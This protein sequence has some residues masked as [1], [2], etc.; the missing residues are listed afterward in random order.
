MTASA[1]AED[2]LR[3]GLDNHRLV[4]QCLRDNARRFPDKVHIHAIDQDKAIT[5]SET[6][7]LCNRFAR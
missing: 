6:W 1:S 2:A 4:Q 5:W 7:R 3:V